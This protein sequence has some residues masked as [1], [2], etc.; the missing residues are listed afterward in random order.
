MVRDYL[1]VPPVERIMFS[2]LLNPKADPLMFQRQKP[3]MMA[4]SG[5][6]KFHTSQKNC[7]TPY[8]I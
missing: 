7:S 2:D 8:I 5:L 4:L 1:S 3:R 6:Q